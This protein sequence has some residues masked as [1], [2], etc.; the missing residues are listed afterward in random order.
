MEEEEVEGKKDEEDK[1]S[2]KMKTKMR[3]KEHDMVWKVKEK[4]MEE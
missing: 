4:E 3:Q 2:T 1:R